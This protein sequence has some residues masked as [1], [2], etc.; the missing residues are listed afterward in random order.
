MSEHIITPPVVP[1]VFQFESHE[2][3]TVI[4]KN[5]VIWF[6]ARDVAT[7]LGY[8]KP[9]GAVSNHCKHAKSFISLD[10]G[11]T[12]CFEGATYNMLMIPERDVFRLIMKSTLP[13]AEKFEDWVVSEVLPAI[14]KHGHYSVTSAPTFPA[15]PKDPLELFLITSD[16]IKQIKTETDARIAQVE[17]IALETATKLEEIEATRPLEPWQAF[18]V[19]QEMHQKVADFFDRYG[20]NRALLYSASWGFLKRHFK[21]PTYSAIPARRYEEALLV[22]KCLTLDQLPPTIMEL[23]RGAKR[24]SRKEVAS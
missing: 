11:E 2:V 19:K 14:R 8:A 12:P 1:A 20:I 3:R 23:A 18:A 10:L 15:L 22:V 7:V 13:A 21:V 9:E 6:V 5:G 24:A 4:D 16:A 17:D